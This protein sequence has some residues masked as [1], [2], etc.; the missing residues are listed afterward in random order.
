LKVLFVASGRTGR[1]GDV[2]KNQGDSLIKAGIDLEYFLIKPGFWNYL[3]AIRKLRN[4]FSNGHYDL[5]HAHYSLCGFIA[6]L[7]GCKPLVVSLM[8]SDIYPSVFARA[9]IKLFIRY[10]WS[11]TIVKTLQMKE[12][13]GIE[14]VHIIPNGVDI[15]RFKP[16]NRGNARQHIGYKSDKKL[17]IFIAVKDRAEKNLGLAMD[18][19]KSLNDNNVDFKH[20][21]NVAN[22]EIPYY[23][24]AADILLLT[25]RREGSVNVVKEAMACNCP[26]VSTDVGDVKWVLGDTEGCYITA[27]EPEDIADKIKAVLDFGRRTNGRNRI[28]DLGLDSQNIAERLIRIYQKV[29][30]GQR[31]LND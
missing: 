3:Y 7:A 8:G 5:T 13:L 28:F 1:P 23:L 25:S 31:F 17:I 14:R 6:G 11:E 10:K 21:Y 19:I 16:I 24:N 12:L 27:F 2:V 4:V 29:I 20:I 30:N 9:F 15:E 26:V 18:A 22:S